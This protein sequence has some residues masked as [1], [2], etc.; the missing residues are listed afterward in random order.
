LA[1]PSG[2]EAEARRFFGDLL[3]LTEVEKP[4]PLRGRGGVWFSLGAQQL[5][6]G[7]EEPFSPDKKS[8]PALSA[9]AG[10]IVALAERL[11]QAGAKVRWD[12]ELPDRRRFF[13]ED[14]CGNRIEFMEAA[15]P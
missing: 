14:P 8:H 12:D 1:A 10:G 3:G 7:V 4:A 13:S 2:C 15:Q 5:H 9:S 6:V 11:A